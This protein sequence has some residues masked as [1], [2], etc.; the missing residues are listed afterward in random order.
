MDRV[1]ME[2]RLTVSVGPEKADVGVLG[3]RIWIAVVQ[4]L[5]NIAGRRRR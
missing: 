1:A 4:I 5:L 2:P 3:F